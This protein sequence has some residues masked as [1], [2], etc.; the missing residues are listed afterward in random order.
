MRFLEGE[1]GREEGEIWGNVRMW[2]CGERYDDCGLMGGGCR[3]RRLLGGSK[4]EKGAMG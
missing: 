4:D 2:G 3:L 1:R